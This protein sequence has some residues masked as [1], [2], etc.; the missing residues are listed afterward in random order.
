MFEKGDLVTYGCKGVCEVKNITTLNLEGIPKDRLYY[1]MQSMVNAGSRI[2]SPVGQEEKNAMRAVLTKEEAEELL[3]QLPECRLC[4]EKDE[5][6]REETYRRIIN[7]SDARGMLCM[8]RTITDY[9]RERV[10]EGRRMPAMDG[11]YLKAAEDN[12]YAELSI[13]MEI[14]RSALKEYMA[15][16]MGARV[17]AKKK[18]LFEKVWRNVQISGATE[19]KYA[20]HRGKAG[21]TAAANCRKS[22]PEPVPEGAL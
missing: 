19:C 9:G 14:P 8:I 21:E 6:R 11:R 22:L 3:G 13:A 4:W 2:F 5:R 12:L 7:H 1:E 20:R 18:M 15:A 16:R 17:N 10:L